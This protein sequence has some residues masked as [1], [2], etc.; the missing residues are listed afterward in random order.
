MKIDQCGIVNFWNHI[1]LDGRDDGW[2]ECVVEK[3]LIIL[4]LGFGKFDYWLVCQFGYF[5]TQT[6]HFV[7]LK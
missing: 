2:W 5:D 1:R 4:E 7:L 3:V 6:Q